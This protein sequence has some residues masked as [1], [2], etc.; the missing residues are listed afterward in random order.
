MRWELN[1]VITSNINENLWNCSGG[2]VNSNQKLE[3]RY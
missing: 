1:Y 2:I 3:Y